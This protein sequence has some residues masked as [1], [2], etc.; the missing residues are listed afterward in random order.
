MGGGA[1]RLKLFVF[2]RCSCKIDKKKP[3]LSLLIRESCRIAKEKKALCITRDAGI[4]AFYMDKKDG[5]NHY[6]PIQCR[7]KC[8]GVGKQDVSSSSFSLATE[9]SPCGDRIM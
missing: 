1:G 3:T 4:V 9:K 6:I 7:G 5:G 2:F 8:W